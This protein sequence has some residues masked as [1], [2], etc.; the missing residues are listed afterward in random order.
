MNQRINPISL[1]VPT[2]AY[3]QA[4]LVPCG[5]TELLFITGQL[6]QD[7]DGNIVYVGN[8]EGQTRHVF[9]RLEVILK[10]A[11]MTFDDVVKI[12]FFLRDMSQS[13]IVSSIR[14]ELFVNSKPASTMVEVSG[15]VKNDCLI[16]IDLVAAKSKI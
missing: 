9:N 6:P 16:E 11:N 2:K 4:V 15:F 1:R 5:T 12:Q 3:S 10:E 14:D 7:I 13:K 8:V